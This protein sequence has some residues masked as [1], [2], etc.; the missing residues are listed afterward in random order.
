[1]PV[2]HPHAA[3]IDIG[4]RSHYVAVGQGRDHVFEFGVDSDSHKQLIATLT[5]FGI[6]SVAMESTGSYWQPLFALLQQ[7]GF[8]VLLVNGNQTSHPRS[9]TDVQDCQRIQLLH[10]L[11]VLRGSFLPDGQTL[12]LRNLTRHRDGLIRSIARYTNKIQKTLR[13]MNIRLDV[14]I[15]DVVGKSGR[16]IIE[17]IIGG[18]QDAHRL[19][20]LADSRVKKSQAELVS[21]LAGQWGDPTLLFE[22]SECYDLLQV[23]ERHV[24]RCDQHIESLLAEARPMCDA[25]AGTTTATAKIKQLKGKNRCTADL[26]KHCTSILGTDLFELPGIGPGVVLTFISEVGTGIQEFPNAAAFA[27]WL[28]LAP[29]NR[30]TG[31]RVVSS[32]TDKGGPKLGKALRDGANALGRMKG[33]DPLVQ[34]FRRIAYKKGRGAAITATA[35]KLAVLLWKAVVEKMVYDPTPSSEHEAELKRRELRRIR[36]HAERFAI[37]IDEISAILG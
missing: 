24:V 13:L 31:G 8:K 30:I 29:N 28:C 1:M 4:S 2:I 14:A 12:Q 11:G 34:F 21:L 32:R 6:T 37:T 25:P 35:R 19:A 20:A 15:R 5:R 33:D 9:K 3:G 16:A 26:R 18:E 27:K 7:S 10:S 17:A 22:L 23:H 36:K